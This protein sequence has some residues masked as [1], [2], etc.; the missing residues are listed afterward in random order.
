MNAKL[1]RF[2]RIYNA[3]LTVVSVIALIVVILDWCHLIKLNHLFGQ[4][5]ISLLLLIFASDYLIRLFMARGKA[6]MLASN[7]FRLSALV[8]TDGVVSEEHL[9]KWRTASVPPATFSRR[10]GT[11]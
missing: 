2:F 8:P 5:T 9:K 4:V 11:I 1:E 10:T 7:T 3:T 6:K